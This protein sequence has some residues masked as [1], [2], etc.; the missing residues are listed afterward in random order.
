MSDSSQDWTGASK[1]DVI[2]IGAGV[3]G[4]TAATLLAKEGRKVL[5]L[6]AR[7][8]IG[9]L[10]SSVEFHPG[11]RS[12]G[13]LSD[14]TLVR[15]SVISELGLERYG[16][17]LRAQA[18][19]PIVLA[20]G[21]RLDLNALSPDVAP[22]VAAG[23]ASFDRFIEKIRPVLAG[24]CDEQPLDLLDLEAES[25]LELLKR[26]LKLRRLGAADMHELLRVAPSPIADWLRELF[27]E[28]QDAD[29]AAGALAIPGLAATFSAPR[30]PGGAA[31][32]LLLEA[33]RGPGVVGGGAELARAVAEAAAD[34]GVQTRTSQS[35]GAIDVESRRATGVILQ[36][37]ERVGAEVV[38]AACDPRT[39]LLD[40]VPPAQLAVKLTERLHNY[41]CRGTTAHL[42]LALSKASGLPS[43][44]VIADG[45]DDVER[46]F[47]ATKYG[48]VPARPVLEVSV[49]SAEV[50]SRCPD[51]HEVVSALVH[52]AP[53]NPV[54]GWTAELTAAMTAAAVA[55]LEECAPGIG[56]TIVASSLST[57]ADLARDYRLTGGNLHHGERAIDQLLVRPVPECSRYATPIAGL[58]L[59]GQG[60]HPGGGLHGGNGRLAAK[61]ILA[62]P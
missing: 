14:T 53:P 6:E 5:C 48:E 31:N 10:A 25:S 34:V 59:C 51:G 21:A 26:G 24:F 52:F 36:S 28:S 12:A 29:R 30:S 44:S 7:D 32:L 1:L 18:S 20:G 49:V 46:A 55:R 50:P 39:A 41:R 60:T 17:K 47:D 40:L 8:A 19:R 37:G 61:H 27:G 3:N 22:D 45:L 35:V 56:Q 42:L 15:P 38:V 11:Y 4:L 9:G 13:V 33:M 23:L 2:V 43:H 57:P 62:K 54:G 16:L 58:F